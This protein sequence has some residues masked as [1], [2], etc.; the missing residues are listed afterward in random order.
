MT[1]RLTPLHDSK[2]AVPA[3]RYKTTAVMKAKG[4]KGRTF[5]T[6]AAMR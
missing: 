5:V 3:P 1:S 6:V 2:A 4:Q